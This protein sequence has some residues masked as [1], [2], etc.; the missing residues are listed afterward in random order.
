MAKSTESV[1]RAFPLEGARSSSSGKGSRVAKRAFLVLILIAATMPF[2]IVGPIQAVFAQTQS[3]TATPGYIN[4]GM[5]TSI[6][7]T[8][9]SA[10]TYTVVVRKPNG[11]LT[12]IDMTF[13]SAGSSKNA[14]YGNGTVGFNATVDAPGTY[15]VFVEQG[16]QEVSST[17]FYATN[18]MVI[19]MDMVN[20]GLCYYIQDA[21]RGS[22]MFPRFFV[23]YLSDG[24]IVTNAVLSNVSYT[25]PSGAFANATWHKPGAEGVGFFIGKVLPNWNYTFV[26]PYYPNATATDV[27]GNKVSYNYMGR[28]FL[29]L[30][31]QLLTDVELMDTK[32]NQTVTSLYAG[33]RIVINATV[34]YSDKN[35]SGSPAVTGFVAPLDPSRGG[36]VTAF[37]GWGSYNVTTKAFGGATPGGLLGSVQLTFSND[38]QSWM[39]QFD[40]ASLPSSAT[41]YKIVIVSSDSASPSN[42]GSAV[43]NLAPANAPAPAISTNNITLPLAL[44]TAVATLIVGLAAGIITSP[45]R[46]ALGRR[47]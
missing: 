29:I 11:N 21:P 15:G 30:P 19:K 34:N 24:S 20:G 37:I 25:L 35:I 27:F 14:T 4:L 22:E 13:A 26:G 42:T 43:V 44:V 5:N 28:P 7:V 40:A 45:V 46:Q 17:S 39:G 10:G 2:A 6:T 12:S 16:G 32:A 38:S 36:T 33:E 31:A 18:Q 23:Y 41:G 3:V 9:P 8:A 47:Q 1:V